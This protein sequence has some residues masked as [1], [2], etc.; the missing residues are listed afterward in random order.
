MQIEQGAQR[1]IGGGA[2]H[3]LL[4]CQVRVVVHFGSVV[5]QHR[6]DSRV[7][8]VDGQR[9]GGFA[10]GIPD[11]GVVAARKILL[12]Q[13]GVVGQ[14]C[15]DQRGVAKIVALRTWSST[16]P[17]GLRAATNA[18]LASWCGWMMLPLRNSMA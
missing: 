5:T 10:V 14:R 13:V 6:D 1:A 4:R 17:S 15:Q 11:S 2:Q 18:T 8:F 7:I 16:A 9:Q 3:G 12:N